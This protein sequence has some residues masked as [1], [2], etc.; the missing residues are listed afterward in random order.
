MFR[1]GA[2]VYHG[3]YGWGRF[4]EVIGRETRMARVH[5]PLRGYRFFVLPSA[6]L[7]TIREFCRQ[8]ASPRRG[9]QLLPCMKNG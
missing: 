5:F 4:A 6:S 1:S 8:R 7:R 2:T 9:W 3:E